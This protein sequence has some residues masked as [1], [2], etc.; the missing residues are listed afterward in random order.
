VVVTRDVYNL[1][2][3]AALAW[4]QVHF[5]EALSYR[6]QLLSI[7]LV[8]DMTYLG[9]HTRNVNQT[10]EI[11]IQNGKYS[12]ADFIETIIH[13]LI[14]LH[15]YV[16]RRMTLV[17]PS[18]SKHQRELEADFAGQMFRRALRDGVL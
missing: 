5:P 1:H 12:V 13:E 15:Q 6:G 16:E 18:L 9:L 8:S 7:H 3:E 14:H 11:W 2:F 17:G 10:S 4:V